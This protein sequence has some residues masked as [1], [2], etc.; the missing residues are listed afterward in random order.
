M[1]TAIGFEPEFTDNAENL[2]DCKVSEPE[3]DGATGGIESMEADEQPIYTIAY[4]LNEST[5]GMF[6]AI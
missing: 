4:I 5:G 1:F 6:I 2:V 3:I